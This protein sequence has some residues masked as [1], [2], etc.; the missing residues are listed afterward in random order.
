MR[1]LNRIVKFV[2]S[3]RENSRKEGM[4]VEWMGKTLKAKIEIDKHY[5]LYYSLL[6]FIY[7]AIVLFNNQKSKQRAVSQ[8]H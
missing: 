4:T 2:E 3:S 1:V 7:E 8:P 6:R 5:M